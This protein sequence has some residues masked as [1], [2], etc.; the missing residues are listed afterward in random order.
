MWYKIK[1]AIAQFMSGRNGLDNL[2]YTALWSGLI[3]SLL[4][5]FLMTGLL[6]LL[7]TA[8]YMYA[9]FRLFSR[10]V[11]KRQAE[12]QRFV[13][14]SS[15][16]TTKAKQFFLRLKNSKEYKYVHCSQC[17]TLIRLKRGVG[18]RSVTCP[19]CHNA[20]NVKS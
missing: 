8:L 6:S 17:R 16:L 3:C 13:Q 20:F 10:N 4:D 18:E 11:Y 7:G 9:V 14:W 5:T 19:K 2:G 15:G 1:A 12:N